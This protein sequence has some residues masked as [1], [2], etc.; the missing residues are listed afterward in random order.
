MPSAAP[1]ELGRGALHE[2]AASLPCGAARSHAL[3]MA[4]ERACAPPSDTHLTRPRELSG[5]VLSVGPHEEPLTVCGGRV[6]R[7]DSMFGGASMLE[8]IKSFGKN[9]IWAPP[10]A[11]AA[12]MPSDARRREPQIMMKPP[13]IDTKISGR[14]RLAR[15]GG[16]EPYF[17]DTTDRRD[18]TETPA[19]NTPTHELHRHVPSRALVLR[20]LLHLSTGSPDEPRATSTHAPAPQGSADGAGSASTNALVPAPESRKHSAPASTP[21][22]ELPRATWAADHLRDGP[23]PSPR[24]T[25]APPLAEQQQPSAPGAAEPPGLPAATTGS[26]AHYAALACEPTCSTAARANRG[27]ASPAGPTPPPSGTSGG[28]LKPRAAPSSPAL[29]DGEPG[30]NNT[31]CVVAAAAAAVARPTPPPSHPEAALAG[32]PPGS[33]VPKVRVASCRCKSPTPANHNEA[34]MGSTDS[35]G[36]SQVL[37]HLIP[38]QDE[39]CRSPHLTPTQPQAAQEWAVPAGMDHSY[40]LVVVKGRKLAEGCAGEVRSALNPDT[41][42]EKPASACVV[43][44]P[45]ATLHPLG[46]TGPVRPRSPG[47]ESAN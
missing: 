23:R 45:S 15:A 36:P 40:E 30:C 7:H 28:A 37:A 6:P 43:R 13:K 12:A 11:L 2:P 9:P 22:R 20:A 25:E 35:T 31:R 41:D 27:A 39:P 3:D 47:A 24:T 32:R 1:H 34:A 33:A 29:Q 17:Q 38:A 19:T 21:R 4:C 18:T 8:E 16:A 26:G 44:H 5:R 46:G 42:A 10:D 14:L